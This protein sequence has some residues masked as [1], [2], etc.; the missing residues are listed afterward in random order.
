VL[1]AVSAS[2]LAAM[3]PDDPAYGAGPPRAYG[4]RGAL[5]TWL[6]R[7]RDG[8]FGGAFGSLADVA[9]VS[10]VGSDTLHDIVVGVLTPSSVAEVAAAIQGASAVVVVTGAGASLSSLVRSGAPPSAA[11][12]RADVE[13][14]WTTHLDRRNTA[15]TA[16]AS[17]V[18]ADAV[19]TRA[20]HNQVAQ[21]ADWCQDRGKGFAVLTQNQDRFH[22]RAEDADFDPTNQPGA[23]YVVEMHG[24]L[25]RGRCPSCGSEQALPEELPDAN[26]DAPDVPVYF[27][28]S[29][30]DCDAMLLPSTVWVGEAYA[31]GTLGLAGRRVLGADVVIF[32]GTSGRAEVIRWLL[33][34]ARF[35]A[36]AATVVVDEDEAAWAPYAAA[37]QFSFV[38]GASAFMAALIAELP[39]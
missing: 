27:T 20:L 15:T 25:Y 29:S 36:R 35:H 8:V 12:F 26:P 37:V 7:V 6:V 16:W 3:V 21:L 11:D 18:S 28:C 33:Y 30:D 24:N 13:A 32:L 23:S 17:N 22:L 1:N 2:E 34:E 19:A 14:F 5:A 10:G 31:A 39:S 4:V 9:S 38:L